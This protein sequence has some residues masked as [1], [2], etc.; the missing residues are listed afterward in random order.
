MDGSSVSLFVEILPLV[1]LFFIFLGVRKIYKVLIRD[2][3]D[4]FNNRR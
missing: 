3:K 2:L 4:I 1:L